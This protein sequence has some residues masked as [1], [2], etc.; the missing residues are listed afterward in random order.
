MARLDSHPVNFPF[1]GDGST[2]SAS[3]VVTYMRKG[4]VEIR[5]RRSATA[6]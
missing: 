1:W 4:Q 5:G 2:G 3:G 6:K